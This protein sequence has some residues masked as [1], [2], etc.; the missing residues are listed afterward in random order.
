MAPIAGCDAQFNHLLR[1]RQRLTDALAALDREVLVPSS[2]E[3]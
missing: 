3:P 1:M 2:R